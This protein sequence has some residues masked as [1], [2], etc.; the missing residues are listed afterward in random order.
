MEFLPQALKA[1]NNYRQFIVY[2]L[3]PSKTR[4]GKT[5]KFPVDYQTRQVSNAHDPKVW[6]DAATAIAAAKSFGAGYGVGF[7]FTD[8]DPFWF[9]D[10]DDCAD[11]KS[12]Q[13]SPLALTL[14]SAFNGAAVE[15]S[16][17][18]HGLHVIGQGI[19]PQH[20]CRNPEHK[21]EFYTSGRF[22]ALTGTHAMGDAGTDHAANLAWLVQYY[23]PPQ[24][25]AIPQEWTNA[26]CEGWNGPVDDDD[27]INR[28][29]RSESARAAFGIKAQF[30][31][32]WDADEPTLSATYP[33]TG[34]GGGYDESRAD[35]AL[36]QHLAFWTGNHCDRIE[37]LM[38]RSKLARPKWDREDYLP[39]T[40]LGV[41]GRQ[42]EW[43]CDKK[44]QNI[45]IPRTSQDD[46]PKPTLVTG[47]TFLSVGQQ[48]EIFT[49]C[50]Y[51]TDEHRALIPG[52]YM[53]TPERFKVIYGGYSMPMDLKNEKVSK[54]AWEAFTESQAFRSPR[55][56][57]TCFRPDLRPASIIERD[58]E[59]SANIWWPNVTLRTIGDVAPFL[60]HIALLCP[61][62]TDQMI[63]LSYMAALVQ[64]KGVKFQWCPLLQGVEGNGKTLL[65]RCIAFAIGNRYTHFPKAAELAS[66]FNDWLYGKIFI[67]VEDIYVS[68]GRLE[69]MEAMKPMITAERQEIEPKGGVKTTKDICANF[70]INTNHKDGL[71]KTNNDRRFA[72]FYTAQQSPNDLKRDGMWGDYFPNVYRWL[73]LEGY[74]IV[75]E[76]L[77]TF[78]IPVE[79]NPA[80]SCKRAPV[81]TSTQSAIAHGLGGIE[82]EV[83]EMVSVGAPGFKNDWISSMFLD[84]LLDKLGASRRVPQNKRR[85]LIIS[86]GY[87]WHP[88]LKEG[89]V[90]NPVSPDNGKPRLYIR[91]DSPKRELLTPGEIAK[92]YEKDQQ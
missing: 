23:F 91:L 79:F 37:R 88:G 68:D 76:F 48:I 89:R 27:L 1:L 63:L 34:R 70:I 24:L 87:D 33:D 54:N 11:T 80:I 64:Y 92:Q 20:S 28:A 29:M 61:D 22:V 65:T 62:K 21:L 77:S 19:V 9:L 82:Q 66:K 38:R 85:D 53:L 90:N 49:G 3:V 18:G 17:S 35:G 12:N 5:D 30:H 41:C 69:I 6:T 45:E 51:V 25:Q 43:L 75:N 55:A 15:I 13:W 7:V 36:A 16:S 52:G 59:R 39:R 83:L 42:R 60:N 67:G 73:D 46:T 31:H 40:I 56:N 72:P 81:T 26:P 78:V 58:G 4:Q 10:I 86:L 74:A 84:R 14:L 32:L 8:N 47:N 2:V 44:P 50:I 71:R 57:T